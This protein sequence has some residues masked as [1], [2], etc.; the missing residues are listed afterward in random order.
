MPIQAD[1]LTVTWIPGDG[2]TRVAYINT[3]NSFVAPTN[4]TVPT[5][6][7][8][9]TNSGQQAV[10][11]GTGNQVTV[12]GLS[13]NT[14]YHIRVYE[15]N[16]NGVTTLYLTTTATN[17]PNSATTLNILPTVQDSGIG[18]SNVEQYAVTISWTQGN[19][20]SRVVYIN[21][22]NSFANPVNGTTPTQNTVWTNLGQQAVYVGAGNAITVTGLLP[23]T[24]YYVR[25]YG[26]NGSGINTTY[27][28][29]TATNNPNSFTTA[30][31]S[32]V[33]APTVQDSGIVFSGFTNNLMTITWTKG[34]GENRVLYLNTSN[35]FINPTNGVVPVADSSWNGLGQQ[36]V[37]VGK[38]NGVQVT[39]LSTGVT[40]FARVYAFNGEGVS[41]VYN[42]T[43]AASAGQQLFTIPFGSAGNSN[44]TAGYQSVNRSIL[45]DVVVSSGPPSITLKWITQ[46][47]A[48]GYTIYRKLKGSISWGAAIA[49]LPGT[50]TQ[51]VDT[52]VSEDVY[53]EYR[54]DRP[55]GSGTAYGYVAT[56]INVSQVDDR[57]KII[58][59]VDDYYSAQLST[60][61]AQLEDDL[62]ADSWR[63]IRSDFSRSAGVQTVRNFISAQYVA[64]AAQV[65]A[66]YILGHIPVP[67]SGNA[68]PDGHPPEH[69]GA[70]AADSYYADINGVWT[71]TSVNNTTTYLKNRNIPGDGKFDQSVIPSTV[72]LEIGRVD[73]YDLPAFSAND[74][75]LTRSYLNKA[76]EYKSKAHTSPDRGLLIDQLDWTGDPLL[77]SGWRTLGPLVGSNNIRQLGYGSPFLTNANAG[78]V[79]TASGG[80]G[81]AGGGLAFTGYTD[82]NGGT[83][84]SV[85]ATPF[86]GVFNSQV[87]SYFGDWD[88]TNNFLRATIASG[89][90]LTNAWVGLPRWVFHHFAFNDHIGYAVKATQN[91]YTLYPTTQ[92]STYDGVTTNRHVALMGDPTLRSKYVEMPRDFQIVNTG[93][94]LSF[95]WTRASDD[96]VLGYHIYRMGNS[97]TPH[98][99][100]TPAPVIGVTTATI[101]I[102]GS[103]SGTAGTK[104]AV[105]AVRLET[106]RSGSFFNTSLGAIASV[107]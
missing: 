10:Y 12:T 104:Y 58:L 20:S 39:G 26:F 5:A 75:E 89:R 91:G 67:Y 105:K 2:S 56:G 102:G 73:L 8:A 88:I 27:L 49:T 6:N 84:A 66:V 34:N 87:G 92:V 11:V 61:I 51:Y 106:S 43:G 59:L 77:E 23:S 17:N 3:I 13:Q 81:A 100:I 95:S 78:Y 72:E 71:D 28:T 83:T 68:S 62:A 98:V 44:V 55:S 69:R 70:W 24:T 21:S 63:V 46:V 82:V 96:K 4:N 65:K 107:P 32:V 40:Y 99:R 53:Y 93:A 38:G 57:G 101:S 30:V 19:A 42:T 79:W 90:A 64:D 50:A 15:F 52:G 76:H 36:P 48:N 74:I 47:T 103:V 25:I 29:T 31:V 45:V 16:T 94:A 60:E 97:T 9:W 35:T 80:G 41:A 37:Y 22:V 86:N 85:A 7:Q 33:N 1:S 18:F 54:I 14:T